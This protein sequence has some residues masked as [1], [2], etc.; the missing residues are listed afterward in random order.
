MLSTYLN[1][2]VRTVAGYAVAWLLSLKLAGP[3]LSALDMDTA[4]AK[5]RA[6]AGFVVAL[7]TVYY[8][9]AKWLEQRY[10]SL[11]VLLGSTKQPLAYTAG[12]TVSAP[13]GAHAVLPTASTVTLPGGVSSNVTYT[14][15]STQPPASAG[16]DLLDAL[17]AI[18]AAQVPDTE[19]PAAA[20]PQ[21]DSAL[22]AD[23][24][25]ATG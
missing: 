4:T 6:T 21:P 10:P 16:A 1:A 13:T 3:V 15:V 2:L 12:P 14:P 24:A 18:D 11:T 7:G 20:E 5:E 17:A 23:P 22:P 25:P 8:A 9:A 19:V